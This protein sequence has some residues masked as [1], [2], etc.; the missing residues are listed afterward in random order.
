[1]YLDHLSNLYPAPGILDLLIPYI[2]IFFSFFLIAISLIFQALEIISNRE[3]NIN[4]HNLSV[5]FELVNSSFI[6]FLEHYGNKSI[7]FEI[8]NV[9]KINSIIDKSQSQNG[10]YLTKLFNF[11]DFGDSTKIK[12]V[13]IIKTPMTASLNTSSDNNKILR[14]F[15]QVVFANDKYNQINPNSLQ[16]FQNRVI[17]KF[18]ADGFSISLID[19]ALSTLVYISQFNNHV[20]ND[21]LNEVAHFSNQIRY[22]YNESTDTP[23]DK[24]SSLDKISKRL[25]NIID[26][27]IV[28]SDSESL[29]L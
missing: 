13:K 25:S 23:T 15:I 21:L 22:L 14:I 11:I 28:N 4:F 27:R 18:N 20:S 9:N 19:G 1:L 10:D 26:I 5:K 8:Q 6:T 24:N 2:F 12:Q 7:F 17:E 16:T 29:T 3:K